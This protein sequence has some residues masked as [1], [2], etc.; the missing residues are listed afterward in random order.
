MTSICFFIAAY[1]SKKPWCSRFY[2]HVR[3]TVFGVKNWIRGAPIPSCLRMFF[4]EYQSLIGSQWFNYIH[5][6]SIVPRITKIC[7]SLSQL[8]LISRLVK[9]FKTLV[10]KLPLQ[11]LHSW[12]TQSY[13]KRVVC[14]PAKDLRL[15]FPKFPRVEKSEKGKILISLWTRKFEC[16]SV[17][18]CFQDFTMLRD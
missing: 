5:Y 6:V 4:K 9:C 11:V 8:W 10:Q 15:S 14:R 13:P 17:Q 3:R 12:W 2:D 16:K 18:L 1:V 7:G